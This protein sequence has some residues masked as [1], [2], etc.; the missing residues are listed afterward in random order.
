MQDEVK[1]REYDSDDWEKA[2]YLVSRGFVKL[3]PVGDKLDNIREC[4][5]N[6][7]NAKCKTDEKPLER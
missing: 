6:L 7:H 5:I 2:E 1:K 4:A 3:N